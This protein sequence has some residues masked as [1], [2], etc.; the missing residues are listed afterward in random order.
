MLVLAK[1]FDVTEET[2]NGERPHPLKIQRST[3]TPVVYE[4]VAEEAGFGFVLG[5]LVFKVSVIST[6]RHRSEHKSLDR[7]TYV[8][9][10]HV[11][12]WSRVSS[13]R[14]SS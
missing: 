10:E 2:L 14:G 9:I 8:R 13:F 6:R 11:F 4:F 3:E 12:E 1:A 7:R 5:E